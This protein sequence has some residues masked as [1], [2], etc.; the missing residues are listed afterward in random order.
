VLNLPRPVMLTPGRFTN[1]NHSIRQK[2]LIPPRRQIPD[3]SMHVPQPRNRKFAASVNVPRPSRR[4]ASE[5]KHAFV[6]ND[7]LIGPQLAA[8]RINISDVIHHCS[9]LR[10]QR[11]RN[12]K[13]NEKETH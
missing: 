5:T 9:G 6:H 13:Q 11:M 12:H 2:Q 8:S 1:P 4:N 7:G 3:V 10:A